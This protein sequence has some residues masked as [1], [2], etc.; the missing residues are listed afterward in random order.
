MVDRAESSLAH[1]F[2]W[3]ILEILAFY[4]LTIIVTV[5][6]WEP[7][8]DT[9]QNLLASDSPTCC[10]ENFENFKKTAKFLRRSF[11]LSFDS[12]TWHPAWHDVRGNRSWS[13]VSRRWI[14]WK[15]KTSSEK[16][17]SFLEVFEVFGPTSRRK[18]QLG[19]SPPGSHGARFAER[20]YP[21]VEANA[22]L[23][24][25]GATATWEQ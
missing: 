17:W 4:Q 8:V 2:N 7:G 5:W 6:S 16:L 12:S 20:K 25:G 15:L 21:S 19:V 24:E 11:Q 13:R 9:R 23:K 22:I 1:C 3:R 10:M 18:I 14:E